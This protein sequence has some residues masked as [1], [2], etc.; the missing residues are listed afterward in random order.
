MSNVENTLNEDHPCEDHAVKPLKRC[1]KP[2]SRPFARCL[3]L[4]VAID[5]INVVHQPSSNPECIVKIL[6]ITYDDNTLQPA[7]IT[8]C[9]S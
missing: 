9:G 4:N 5:H 2:T 1:S 6:Q 8:V 7:I 3:K